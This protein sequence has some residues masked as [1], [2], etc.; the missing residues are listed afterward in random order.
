VPPQLRM[1]GVETMLRRV[2]HEG[3]YM[4]LPAEQQRAQQM[5]H[6]SSAAL[7]LEQKDVV[8]SLLLQ[9]VG[10][11]NS[12]IRP[13]KNLLDTGCSVEVLI[14][15]DAATN[16]GTHPVAGTWLLV[17]VGG[18]GGSLG[19]TAHPITLVLGG[20]TEQNPNPT[21]LHGAYTVTV[22]P[23]VMD[24]QLQ[25][26]LGGCHVVLGQPFL[27]RGLCSI[28]HFTM[29]MHYSPAWASHQCAVL[30]ASVPLKPGDA[31]S[32]QSPLL[33]GSIALEPADAMQAN[34]GG[35]TGTKMTA[36]AM[37]PGFPQKAPVAT[38]DEYLRNQEFRRQ[39]NLEQARAAQAIMRESMEKAAA[40]SAPARPPLGRELTDSEVER[41][42]T[43]VKE[44]LSPLLPS[45]QGVLPASTRAT[46]AVIVD[47]P[48]P[49]LGCHEVVACGARVMCAML[50]DEPAPGD[51]MGEEPQV[52]AESEAAAALE[53]G[54]AAPLHEAVASGVQQ[55]QQERP[56]VVRS[57][58]AA[59]A[60]GLRI[61][62]V[63]L[64]M[65]LAAL[66]VATAVGGIGAV[67]AAVQDELVQGLSCVLQ[68][69]V[70][71]M[72]LAV[73][74]VTPVLCY[75]RHMFKQLVC[76]CCMCCAAVALR[77]LLGLGQYWAI[78][79]WQLLHPASDAVHVT[80]LMVCVFLVASIW[81]L[82][83]WNL[84][85]LKHGRK[86]ARM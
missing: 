51:A 13:M 40:K 73:F 35:E 82:L 37:R 66:L 17:G 62:F 3:Q 20:V 50:A 41:I 75:K 2:N 44:M 36:V 83:C 27:A 52:A 9:K 22:Y 34:A 33:T 14:S 11:E 6:E 57:S 12:Y 31:S 45:A 49:E 63:R 4:P 59:P 67:M 24:K 58:R 70:V 80:V 55:M 26:S 48:V 68:V 81:L 84:W 28:D 64:F 71:Y 7:Y 21:P 29:R 42:A 74:L 15:E 30:R 43:R 56:R 47:Q 8:T 23:V 53:L 60:D 54:A 77:P 65:G 76:M 78:S 18:V 1:V 39:R 5:Q 16:V 85:G 46:V 38:T 19:R 72:L 10:S 69:V 79:V 25:A 32:G 86:A 61:S